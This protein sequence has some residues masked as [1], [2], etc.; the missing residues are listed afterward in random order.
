MRKKDMPEKG[1]WSVRVTFPGGEKAIKL[2][3]RQK[4]LELMR[5]LKL[6]YGDVIYDIHLMFFPQ[7]FWDKERA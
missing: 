3:Y 5:Y 2:L 1:W 4:A 6:K 7:D